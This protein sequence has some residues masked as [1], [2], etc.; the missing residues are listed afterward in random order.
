MAQHHH[1]RMLH[2]HREQI[3]QNIREALVNIRT[4]DLPQL[5]WLVQENFPRTTAAVER[6]QNH[7]TLAVRAVGFIEWKS[8]I[9]RSLNDVKVLPGKETSV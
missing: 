9:P 8:V 5:L 2:D 3:L 6:L 4:H 1:L 7:I